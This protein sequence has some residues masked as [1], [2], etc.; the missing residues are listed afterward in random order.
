MIAT[1]NSIISAIKVIIIFTFLVSGA[2][3]V[4]IPIFVPGYK[5]YSILVIG[6]A[7]SALL[8]GYI[9][10][11]APA[12]DTLPIKIGFSFCY[13]IVTTIFVFLFSLF[14]MLNIRGA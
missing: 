12:N 1:K 4:L 14:I 13:A 7:I 9:G 8:G 3:V 5:T 11:Q 2:Y 6:V 10:Y